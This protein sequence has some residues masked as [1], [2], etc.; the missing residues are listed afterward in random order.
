MDSPGTTPEILQPQFDTDTNNYLIHQQKKQLEILDNNINKD[1]WD[2]DFIRSLEEEFDGQKVINFD[3]YIKWSLVQN[4]Q[5]LPIFNNL[6]YFHPNDGEVII[7][8]I[9]AFNRFFNLYPGIKKALLDF[10][11]FNFEKKEIPNIPAH[12]LWLKECVKS[13]ERRVVNYLESK[14]MIEYEI[15]KPENDE[16][17][18]LDIWKFLLSTN[19]N[20]T[21]VFT[22]RLSQIAGYIYNPEYKHRFEQCN[23]RFMMR[24]FD[25]TVEF[26]VKIDH[27]SLGMKYYFSVKECTGNMFCSVVNQYFKSWLADQSKDVPTVEEIMDTFKEKPAYEAKLI[28]RTEAVKSISAIIKNDKNKRK[29]RNDKINGRKIDQQKLGTATLGVYRVIRNS[30]P[31]IRRYTRKNL[32]GPRWRH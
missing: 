5:I 10:E 21:K 30:T 24:T 28:S 19:A 25:P 17:R 18:I 12:S 27:V 13:L 29:I 11:T 26:L 6:P 8:W 7:D 22:V 15:D 9:T 14:K 32:R 20:F 16:L 31:S 2:N 3:S 1:N 4:E 23:K